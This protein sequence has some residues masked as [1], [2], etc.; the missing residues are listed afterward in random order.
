MDNLEDFLSDFDD[1]VDDI[2]RSNYQSYESGIRRWLA[3]LHS[4]LIAKQ[5]VDGLLGAV[6]IQSWLKQQDENSHGGMGNDELTWPSDQAKYL[7]IRLAL[8]EH[9][10]NTK[11]GAL[12]FAHQYVSTSTRL[13]ENLRE[14]N[15]Q[16]FEGLCR[17][18]RKKIVREFGK[19]SSGQ[20]ILASD[21]I[22]LRSDNE[23]KLDEVI[24]KSDLL[25]QQI[26]GANFISDQEEKQRLIAE[27]A[28]GRDLLKAKQIRTNAVKYTIIAA[29]LYIANKFADTALDEPAKFLLNVLYGLFGFA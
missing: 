24:S 29:L 5:V 12:D 9:F 2:Q 8:F 20:S 15:D 13:D 19:L 11:Q 4:H 22:V 26:S 10:A 1:A 28:S 17:D 3:L 7:A 6:N 18:L 14:L 16:V 27:I 21:R 25:M 23:P